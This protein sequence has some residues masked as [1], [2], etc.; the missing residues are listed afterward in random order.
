[1]P[2]KRA[3]KLLET[4]TVKVTGSLKNAYVE[5]T[6]PSQELGLADLRTHLLIEGD[7][8]HGGVQLEHLLAEQRLHAQG[9]TVRVPHHHPQH[10]RN[11]GGMRANIHTKQT[12]PPLCMAMLAAR[13]SQALRWDDSD[14][15]WTGL[16]YLWL[17]SGLEEDIGLFTAY[18]QKQLKIH[19]PARISLYRVT[20]SR[21]AAE[22]EKKGCC[23]FSNCEIVPIG[24]KSIVG[25]SGQDPNQK[26]I[27]E[28]I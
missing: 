22:K 3:N 26:E 19:L 14:G 16:G 28:S 15:L 25:S 9:Q 21:Q 23:H 12:G 2:S 7:G 11:W 13:D 8:D 24:L 6:A 5:C 10:T 27:I 20:H 1:M 17:S 4:S 18:R